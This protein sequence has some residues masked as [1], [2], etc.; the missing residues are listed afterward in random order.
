MKDEQDVVSISKNSMQKKSAGRIAVK[1]PDINAGS[2]SGQ[3]Q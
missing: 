2:L 1:I 3:T